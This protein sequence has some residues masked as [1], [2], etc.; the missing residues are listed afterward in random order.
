M[1][2]ADEVLLIANTSEQDT[3]QR[4][5]A[6]DADLNRADA[7]FRVPLRNSTNP[8]AAAARSAFTANRMDR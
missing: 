8:S 6:G 7:S 3:L 5:T 4:E 1:L 2:D